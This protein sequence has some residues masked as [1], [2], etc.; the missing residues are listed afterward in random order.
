MSSNLERVIE[1]KGK[2]SGKT[3]AII[4]GI[5]G[6]EICGIKALDYL[7]NYLKPD[8]GLVY[9][10]YGNP[11]AIEKGIRFI[12]M[13]LNRAFKT[14]E[15]LTDRERNSYER[16]RALEIIPFLRRC[17]AILDIHSSNSL[18]STPFLICEPQ[19]F[20]IAER[21]PF[22]IRSFGW[23]VL[24]PGSTDNFANKNGRYAVCAECGSNN[25]PQSYDLALKAVSTFLTIFGIIEG[26]IPSKRKNQKEIFGKYVYI[27][28]ENFKPIRE[29]N[30]FENLT[31]GQLI[32]FDG[33]EKIYSES[34]NSVI[35]FARNRENPNE[36]AFIIGT[37]NL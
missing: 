34:D 19:S 14:D 12:D 11:R 37:N 3:V 1:L 6:N 25:D 7:Q 35:V 26:P 23:D 24:E 9:L 17:D 10:I 20:F 15:E 2:D 16:K 21:I 29:F 30:D 8:A 22:P 32:G 28:K 36:E 33:Q 27:T 5:H 31:K 4:G 13:N 18:N